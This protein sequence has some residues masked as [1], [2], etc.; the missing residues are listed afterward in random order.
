MAGLLIFLAFVLFAAGVAV[1][2]SHGDERVRWYVTW[3][4][5]IA[6]VLFLAFAVKV[7]LSTVPS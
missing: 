2:I 5:G 3:Y 6:G 1:Q 4:T 7:Y